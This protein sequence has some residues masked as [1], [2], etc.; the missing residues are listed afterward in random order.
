MKKTFK[1]GDRVYHKNLRQYG[2]FIDYAWESD[3]ECDVN[4]EAED[5]RIEQKHVSLD[6]LELA[7]QTYDKRIMEVLRQRR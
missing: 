4:F 7:S 3:E 6:M 5:G 1:H 2:F